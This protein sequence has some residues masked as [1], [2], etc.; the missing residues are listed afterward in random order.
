VSDQRS[1]FV[2][3]EH[4]NVLASNHRQFRAF[5]ERR[6]GDAADAEDILQ[7]AFLKT[8]ERGDTIRDG[9]SIVAW[10][11]R[12]LRNAVIDHYRHHGAER[13]ALTR[14]RS[15]M[16]DVDETEPDVERAICQCIHRLL[17]TIR[18]DYAV[19]LR[20]VDLEDASISEVASE[21]QI[22]ENNARVRLHRARA[23]LRKKLELSCGTCTEHG[24][25][26]CSCRQSN[27][28]LS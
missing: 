12:L 14:A 10:F 15:L 17:P 7:A 13:R 22:T 27:D 25:L 28:R 8:V 5:L 2:P 20:R 4:I 16:L 9:E 6:V 18:E 11:Y 24:C 23:A 19:M 1:T 3:Q 21:A 26:D